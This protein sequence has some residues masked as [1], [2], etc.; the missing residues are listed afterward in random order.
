MTSADALTVL[1][2]SLKYSIVTLN[3]K[4]ASEQPKP[5]LKPNCR[6]SVSKT[7]KNILTEEFQTDITGMGVMPLYL[8]KELASP[9][10]SLINWDDNTK[11]ESIWHKTMQKHASKQ[12]T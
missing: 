6:S 7:F 11:T 9:V 4:I 8:F 10:S 12:S 1:P 2:L 3:V 5:F